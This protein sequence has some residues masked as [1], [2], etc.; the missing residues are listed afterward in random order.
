MRPMLVGHLC[1]P[2]TARLGSSVEEW[3]GRTEQPAVRPV[4]VARCIFTT[5]ETDAVREGERIRDV[6]PTGCR[7]PVRWEPRP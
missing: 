3:Q 1:G 4:Y 5:S 7:T 6:C 2:T